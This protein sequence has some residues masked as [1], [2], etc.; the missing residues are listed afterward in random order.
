MYA[1]RYKGFDYN[2][3]GTHPELLKD[4]PELAATPVVEE[5]ETVEEWV[6]AGGGYYDNAVTGERRYGKPDAD[7]SP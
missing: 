6:H 2:A 1:R 5:T 4:D 7:G 3:R